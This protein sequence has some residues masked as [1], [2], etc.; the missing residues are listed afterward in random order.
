MTSGEQTTLGDVTPDLDPDALRRHIEG[1]K[2]SIP[3]VAEEFGVEEEDVRRAIEVH[4]IN[5]NP[6]ATAT[7]TSGPAK[8][9]VEMDPDEFDDLVGGES[10]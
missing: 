2:W 10:A 1:W 3:D 5:Y 4:D 9:L 7:S 6:M 8:K